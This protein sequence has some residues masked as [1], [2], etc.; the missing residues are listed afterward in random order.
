LVVNIQGDEPLLDPR[1]IDTLVKVLRKHKDIPMA[2]LCFSS[3]DKKMYE[4]VNVVK[5]VKDK[6][7][8]ALYF[9]RSPIPYYRDGR[10]VSFFKHIGI[11]AYRR[12]FLMQLPLLRK[13]FLEE[14]EK[15]EQLRIVENGFKIKV[16]KISH[17]S[18]GIDTLDDLNEVERILS[19]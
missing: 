6:D 4:D 12:S 7:D 2:T 13:S 11:Y 17:D 1:S 15:L 5:L 16:V 18:V 10:D 8:C 3:N 9:S 19:R 14:A